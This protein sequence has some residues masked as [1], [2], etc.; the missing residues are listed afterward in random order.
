LC[1]AGG[2]DRGDRDQQDEGK[3]DMRRNGIGETMSF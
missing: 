3:G 2:E 1:R